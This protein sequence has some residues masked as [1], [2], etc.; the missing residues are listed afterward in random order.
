[1][2]LPEKRPK[3]KTRKCAHTKIKNGKK[4]PHTRKQSIL[5]YKIYQN[6][7]NFQK[8]N[9]KKIGTEVIHQKKIEI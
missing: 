2:K 3:I 6:C 4:L 5:N 1:M 7:K 8:M 9:S